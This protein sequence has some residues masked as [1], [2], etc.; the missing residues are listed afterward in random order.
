MSKQIGYLSENPWILVNIPYIETK[1]F[2]NSDGDTNWTTQ[3]EAKQLEKFVN[4][5]PPQNIVPAY[6]ARISSFTW[7]QFQKSIMKLDCSFY[8]PNFHS[9][10]FSS[11][12]QACIFF[13]H[14]LRP[15][16]PQ[17]LLNISKSD[18]NWRHNF[19]QILVN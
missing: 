3:I 19:H 9:S 2:Q 18:R 16:L 1:F 15:I 6:S 8:L 5:K 7:T 4:M 11:F 10:K 17:M 14:H 12:R 13:W